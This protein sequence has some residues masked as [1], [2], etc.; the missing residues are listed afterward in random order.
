M[1]LTIIITTDY[2]N[3]FSIRVNNGISKDSLKDVPFVTDDNDINLY[4]SVFILIHD[5]GG[6]NR[7]NPTRCKY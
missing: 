4:V 1:L 5:D 6:D 3:K 2:I 7:L